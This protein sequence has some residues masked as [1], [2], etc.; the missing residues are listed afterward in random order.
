[1]NWDIGEWTKLFHHAQCGDGVGKVAGERVDLTEIE[2]TDLAYFG[3]CT[4]S[5]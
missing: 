5:V 2:H 4:T 3:V 1:M